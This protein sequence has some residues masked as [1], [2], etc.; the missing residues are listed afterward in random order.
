VLLQEGVGLGGLGA[1]LEVL[2]MVLI[3][4]IVSANG[5]TVILLLTEHRVGVLAAGI[6]SNLPC[7][8]FST[9][10][11]GQ[12]TFGRVGS[13]W[14]DGDND[15]PKNPLLFGGPNLAAH[16]AKNRRRSRALGLSLW[17][18]ERERDAIEDW[19]SSATRE[20]AFANLFGRG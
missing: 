11:P 2:I 7:H 18:S 16:L 15:L 3:C 14:R 17:V 4:L 12:K 9:L 5:E 10:R 8:E 13:V 6:G 1:R 20:S 19:S